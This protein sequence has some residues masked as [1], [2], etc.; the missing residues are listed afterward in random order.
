MNIT[1]MTHDLLSVAEASKLLG[2]PRLTLYRW[3][4]KGRI[5]SVRFGGILY[6]PRS[7]IERI[8]K[9]RG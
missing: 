8:K 1:L 5:L 4:K 6:I 3:V 9:E 2:K 7:E